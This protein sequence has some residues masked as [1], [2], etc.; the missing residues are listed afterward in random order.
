M[1]DVTWDLVRA[2]ITVSGGTFVIVLGFF[3]MLCLTA[4][5]FSGIVLGVVKLYEGIK[6]A[7]RRRISK[8]KA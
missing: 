1:V 5:A 6:N 3:I 4:I 8:Q 7:W 2:W